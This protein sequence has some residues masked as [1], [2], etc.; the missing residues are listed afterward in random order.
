MN[1]RTPTEP[2]SDR[3]HADAAA[4]GAAPPPEALK[5]VAEYLDLAIEAAT[6]Q[7]M[8]TG[9]LLGLFYYYTHGIASGARQR[10]LDAGAPAA[11][12]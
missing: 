1:A 3:K 8:G 12:T 4:A 7:G 11:K 6:A 2:M 9:E 5:S 10:A